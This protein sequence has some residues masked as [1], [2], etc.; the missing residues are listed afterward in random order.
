M[1][2][3]IIL[4][5]PGEAP[6]PWITVAA[7]G[8]VLQRG[9]LPPE[10]VAP[11]F[12]TEDHLVVPG[13]DVLVRWFDLPDRND[14]QARS[15]VAFLMQDDIAGDDDVHIAVGRANA[16]GQRVAAIVR[17]AVVDG[18]VAQAAARGVTPTAILPNF[19]VLPDSAEEIVAMR[20]G[21]LVAVRGQG[22]AFSL[23]ADLAE[24]VLAG[25]TARRL[26]PPEY[27]K[28]LVA[29]ARDP[30]V[31]LLQGAFGP[32]GVAPPETGWRR[33]AVLA[34]LLLVSPALIFGAQVGRDLFAA[35][36]LEARAE[37]AAAR[38][39]PAAA[40]AEDPVAFVRR[41]LAGQQA[42]DRFATL[43]ADLFAA[44]EKT[45]GAQLDTLVYAPDGALHAGL[46][47]GNYSDMDQLLAAGR[48]LDLDIA[49]ESTVTEGA[50]IT[51]DVTV[52]RRP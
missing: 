49:A 32:R 10:A 36:R 29:A 43:A 50:R 52:R 13:A 34:G 9:L 20:V 37:A 5:L 24:T 2:L 22:L 30:E 25:R 48:Q 51:S 39:W 8:A 44:V 23:E 41:R 11:D 15:A 26:S 40:R 6:W 17:R 19:L 3:R 4:L 33:A 42:A 47:Y 38:A 31:N 45:P 14:V 46:S 27:D 18:W 16:E 28:A 35:S 1:T 21:G 7:D 12:P